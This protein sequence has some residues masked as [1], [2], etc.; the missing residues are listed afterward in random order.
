MIAQ[1]RDRVNFVQLPSARNPPGIDEQHAV[2]A[3]DRCQ[4]ATPNIRYICPLFYA[5]LLYDVVYALY[6][7]R[8]ILKYTSVPTLLILD[9]DH[10]GDSLSIPCD[11][12]V[13]KKTEVY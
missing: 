3:C 4:A 6:D 11:Q 12:I 13:H 2:S 8:R 10:A 1:A 7:I 9:I 5:K